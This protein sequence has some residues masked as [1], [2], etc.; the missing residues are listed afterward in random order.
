MNPAIETAQINLVLNFRLL[1]E[2]NP[3]LKS[4][5]ANPRYNLLKN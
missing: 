3:T 5:I 1:P 2:L 4:D